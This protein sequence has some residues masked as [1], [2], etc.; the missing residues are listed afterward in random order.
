MFSYR[1]RL[2]MADLLNAFEMEL[3]FGA[4]CI[5]TTSQIWCEMLNGNFFF[6]TNV[7]CII[8][9]HCDRQRVVDY[10]PLVL[11]M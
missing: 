11:F 10:L 7:L 8:V 1:R 5:I 2:S 4:L 6:L 3:V 9:T